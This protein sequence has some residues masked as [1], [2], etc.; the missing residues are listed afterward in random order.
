VYGVGSLRTESL[1]GRVYRFLWFTVGENSS[2]FYD[3][4]SRKENLISTNHFGRRKPRGRQEDR[5]RPESLF[6]WGLPVSF[7]SKHLACQT[8]IL[9]HS[10]LSST[11]NGA[12]T[13]LSRG[14][15]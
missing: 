3:S 2:S 5:T 14:Q 15:I 9:G 6:F 4:F 11:R 12:H 8:H 1:Q 10:V 7:S 13:N